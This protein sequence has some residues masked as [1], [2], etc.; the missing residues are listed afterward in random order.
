M[1][2]RP[3]NGLS[4]QVAGAP[5]G[6]EPLL[7][8]LDALLDGLQGGLAHSGG[9]KVA[10]LRPAALNPD[11]PIMEVYV[12]NPGRDQLPHSAAQVVETEEDQTVSAFGNREQRTYSYTI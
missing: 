4:A 12:R 6:K 3:Q 9:P 11:E 8:R 7:A 2:Y 1:V 10:G 5:A